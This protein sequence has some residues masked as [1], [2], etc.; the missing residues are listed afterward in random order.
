MKFILLINVL[1][2]T[3]CNDKLWPIKFLIKIEHKV[4]I[5]IRNFEVIIKFVLYFSDIWND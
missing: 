1:T 3:H 2:D 5:I 4:V